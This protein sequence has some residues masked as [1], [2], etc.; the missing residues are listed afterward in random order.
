MLRKLTLHARLSL[1]LSVFLAI[2]VIVGLISVVLVSRQH[3]LGEEEALNHLARTT[4]RASLPLVEQSPDPAKALDELVIR[5][6]ADLQSMVSLRRNGVVT[7]QDR[8]PNSSGSAPK[9]FV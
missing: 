9:W 2:A 3:V 4:I 5:L 8:P 6:Q 1:L 7:Q